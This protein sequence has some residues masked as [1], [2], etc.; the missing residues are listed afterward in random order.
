[1]TNVIANDQ[2]A[3]MLVIVLFGGC[4]GFL[5]MFVS[6]Y[7]DLRK[8]RDINE[9]CNRIIKTTEEERNTYRDISEK[10]AIIIK[11]LEAD[12]TLAFRTAVKAMSK[13][14]VLK[15]M[16]QRNPNHDKNHDPGRG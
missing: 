4:A 3:I 13:Q 2:R 16:E 14:D 6:T 10:Q 15:M 12:A 9:I 11:V 1:M 8:E 5:M 7:L